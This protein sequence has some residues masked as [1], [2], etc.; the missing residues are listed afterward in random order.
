MNNLCPLCQK[1]IISTDKYISE[2][3]EEKIYLVHEK[4]LQEADDIFDEEDDLSMLGKN[5]FL[6]AD[7]NLELDN[8]EEE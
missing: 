7:D 6:F 3:I 4:C 2:Q 8:S 5:M 1:P